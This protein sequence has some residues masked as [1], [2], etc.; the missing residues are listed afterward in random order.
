M[1]LPYVYDALKR[2]LIKKSAI[3]GAIVAA[4]YILLQTLYALMGDGDEYTLLRSLGVFFAVIIPIIIII[5]VL[6]SFNALKLYRFFKTKNE[7]PQY[8]PHCRFLRGDKAQVDD[9]YVMKY[10]F[11]ENKDDLVVLCNPVVLNHCTKDAEYLDLYIWD[12]HHAII[13][14]LAEDLLAGYEIEEE[15]EAENEEE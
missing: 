8:H 9:E 4:I 15:T 3:Y 11:A 10:E 1:N 2:Q 7:D 12:T 13:A 5:T 6:L 14:P